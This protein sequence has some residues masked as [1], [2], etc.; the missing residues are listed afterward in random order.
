MIPRK[1]FLLVTLAALAVVLFP[2]APAQAELDVFYSDV[3]NLALSVDAAGT[4]ESSA[5][6]QV[7]KPAGATV[8]KAFLFA[9]STGFT[10]VTPDDGSIS[11]DGTGVAWAP[12]HTIANGIASMN[13]A[14]DVTALVKDKVNAAAPGS[15]AFTV[16]ETDTFSIDGEV[17]AVVFNDASAKA[18][19][20]YLMYGAQQT[21]GDDFNIS[22]AEPLKP[23]SA[24]SMGLG[25]SFG[26]QPAGQYSQIDVNGARLT[27]SAGGYDDG[28]GENGALVT[29][30]GLGDSL[31]DPLNALATDL[32]CLGIAPRCDDELYDLKPFVPAG[33]KSIAVETLNPSSDD[34]IMFAAFELS[35]VTATVGESV[36]LSPSGTRAQVG[37][38]HKLK[39][40]AQDENGDPVTGRIVTLKVTAGPSDGKT[41]EA[42]TNGNGD[43]SF[44]YTSASATGTDSLRASYVDEHG[45]THNSNVA[46]H[47][48]APKVAGTL[49]GEWPYNGSS[50]PLYYTYGGGHRYL[51]NVFQGAVNWNDAGTKVHISE[52]PGT[53]NAVHIPISDVYVGDDWWGATVY[54]E[55]CSSCSYT[56]NAIFFNQRTL[57]PESDA[58]R[59]KVATHEFG[60]ALGLDHPVGTTTASTPSVMWQGRLGGSVKSTPQALDKSRVNGMY[61]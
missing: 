18:R 26:Y 2:T 56:R 20:L 30:G 24:A 5:E 35:A 9:A 46:T 22:L 4:N 36:L 6:V 43:A 12:E 58:Q 28:E 34:N 21:S 61:P 52:W 47:T 10:G 50:L 37:R 40:H 48:W 23:S 51:G 11:L 27:T 39:A 29:V 15:V 53:P 55:D 14:A 13:V 32:D 7:L 38:S 41:M 59:T 54:P 45:A 42:F 16:A 1:R 57:D 44:S 49:G 33:G 31:D 8:K 25:I 17:L 19:S 60:H 3:G